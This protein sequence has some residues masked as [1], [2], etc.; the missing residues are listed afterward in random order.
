MSEKQIAPAS[1]RGA[2]PLKVFDLEYL[3]LHFPSFQT[4]SLVSLVLRMN[5]GHSKNSRELPRCDVCPGGSQETCML[6]MSAA[7][8][9]VLS[10]PEM[11]GKEHH[12]L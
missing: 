3:P 2:L 11:Q 12:S 10:A 9:H 5:R 6:P 8:T 4:V 1:L 7:L